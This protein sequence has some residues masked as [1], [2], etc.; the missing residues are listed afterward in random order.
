MIANIKDSTWYTDTV[1]SS[2]TYNAAAK[3][4]TFIC[5]GTG[6]SKRISISLTKST[7]INSSGFPLGTYTV[8]ATPNLQLA[9]LTPQ[10]NSE[11]NLVYTPNGTV[12]AGSGTVVVTA[13][14]SVK[15]QITGTYS[16]T[17]L[18]NNYDS[19]GNVVSVTIA[20]ISGGGFNKVPYTFKSN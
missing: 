20:N 19:N 16:F 3:T 12:A 2:L 5:E 7:S 10:K 6:F 18:V 14:D 8:D 1:T 17:T 4:K 9:Y 11:G 13:V 15:N